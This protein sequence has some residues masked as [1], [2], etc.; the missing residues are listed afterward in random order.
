MI[1]AMWKH[2]WRD[3][4]WSA[5]DQKWDLVVIGGGITG[6][7]IFAEALRL[8]LETLLID[9][10]DFASGTSSRSTKLVHGGL[11]YLRQAQVGVTRESVRERER[12]MK[13]AAGLVKPLGFYLTTFERDQMPGWMLGAGLAVYDLIAG[14]WAHKKYSAEDL[15]REVPALAGANLRG[16]YHYFDA[17]TDD[18]RL[19]LRVIREGVRRGGTAINYVKALDL[20]RNQAGYVNGVVLK[21]ENPDAGGRTLEIDARAVVNATGTWSDVLRAKVGGTK[22]L[23]PIR[24][25]HLTFEAARIPIPEAISLMHPRDSRAVF[26]IPWEGATIIGTT[27]VDH[28]DAL[29]NEP[30]TSAAEATY[31]LEAAKHAFP[32]LELTEKDIIASWSGVRSVIDTGAENPS[33]ESRD[34]ALWNEN[35]LLT[36]TGGKL[37]TFRI[38]AQ[39]AL[40]A[41]RHM[42]PDLSPPRSRR[43]IVD[44][45]DAEA[46]AGFKLEP[47]SV[48]RLLGRFGVEALEVANMGELDTI[49]PTPTLWAEIAHAA[50]AEGVLHLDDLLLR[51]GRLGILLPDGGMREL[52]RIRALAQP[53]LQWSDERWESEVVRY[54]SIW[55]RHYGTTFA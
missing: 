34:H 18:A 31:I 39:D 29:D 20:L 40:L 43:R 27:D 46:L 28:N 41:L 19:V 53:R 24:G 51:R 12:L 32:S 47:D 10:R 9:A 35:G 8:G 13:E 21:D 30:S 1:S 55:Q 7:G 15:Q 37:T 2:G 14:K 3:S 17:Q 45:V 44:A 54:R 22:R 4:T 42:I 16:G 33:K 38:M 5:L 50:N 36:V 52:P 6:A 11:R 26:A 23:R 48:Q 25:S 49:G